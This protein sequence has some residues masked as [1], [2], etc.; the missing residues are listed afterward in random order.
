[1]DGCRGPSLADYIERGFLKD[2]DALGVLRDIASG[3][4]LL[5]E[6]GGA[7]GAISSRTILARDVGGWGFADYG[8]SFRRV[9]FGGSAD[10][11][12]GDQLDP[13]EAQDD[14][15]G[16][17]RTL[18]SCFVPAGLEEDSVCL[19]RLRVAKPQFAPCAEGLLRFGEPP[20]TNAKEFL[21]DLDARFPTIPVPADPSL[22]SGAVVR[23]E[24]LDELRRS[25]VASSGSK[26]A[27]VIRGVAGSG[28]THLLSAL[29]REVPTS[30]LLWAKCR[31]WEL[32]PF[33]AV[34]QLV[35]GLVSE[36]GMP[37]ADLVRQLLAGADEFG[38]FV[39][40]LLPRLDGVEFDAGPVPESKAADDVYTEGVAEVLLRALGKGRHV[41][42]VEDIHWL[43]EASRKVLRRVVD[44]CGAS[45][46]L[47]FTARDTPEHIPQTQRFLTTI[48]ARIAW[49]E[50]LRPLT[51]EQSARLVTA[52]VSALRIAP[53]HSRALAQIADG[54]PLGV[55]EVVRN[56]LDLGLLSPNWTQWRLDTEGLAVLTLPKRVIDLIE[57][58]T[59]RLSPTT[60]RV[61][62][63][64]AVLGDE[65]EPGVLHHAPGHTLEGVRA[66]MMDAQ[67]LSLIERSSGQSRRFIHKCVRDA[68]TSALS[69]RDLQH[70]HS[71]V[72][73]ALRVR[74]GSD[75][76]AQR[77]EVVY[78][79]A[80]HASCAAAICDVDLAFA[81]NLEAGRRAFDAFDNARAVSFLTVANNVA[82]DAQKKQTAI[83]F[84]IAE[85]KLRLGELDGSLADFT[86][87]LERVE[88]GYATA[89]AWSR[90]ATI[91]EARLDSISTV[92][93]L[94]RAFEALGERVP[95][96]A[97]HGALAIL[98][99][100]GSPRKPDPI[101][102]TDSPER[103]RTE[104]LVELLVQYSRSTLITGSIWAMV[105]STTRAQGLAERLGPS[106]LLS[107]ACVMTALLLTLLHRKAAGVQVT[108]RALALA[109]S[110]DDPAAY[111]HCLVSLSA[112][113]G[114]QGDIEGLRT[115][116]TEAVTRYPNWMIPP[117]LG[118]AAC[119]LSVVE[120]FR[121]N[122]HTDWTWGNSASTRA[123]QYEGQALVSELL[124]LRL[125]AAAC[126]RGA[127]EI[128]GEFLGQLQ[129]RTL[130]IAK[131]SAYY[132]WT[133]G[134]RVRTFTES[135]DLGE[136]FEAIVEEVSRAQL[137]P[138]RAHQA[139]AEYYV[140]VAHARV[141][142]CFGEGL[143]ASRPALDAL[144]LAARE[145]ELAV[146]IPLIDAH[147]R[148]VRACVYLFKGNH[149]KAERTFG[150]AEQL[151]REQKAPWVLYAVARGR[152]HMAQRQG[153]GEAARRH[154]RVAER[155][156]SE[157]G[158]VHRLR[159]IREEFNLG[160]DRDSAEQLIMDA[161]RSERHVRA[162]VQ[163]SRL[164]SGNL[165]PDEKARQVLDEM[166]AAFQAER[167]FLLLRDSTE[168]LLTTLGGNG[169]LRVTAARVAGQLDAADGESLDEPTL[170]QVLEA[171]Q[172]TV[173][174]GTA[175]AEPTSLLMVPLTVQ[176]IPV[177]AVALRSASGGA[178]FTAGDGELLTALANQVPIALELAHVLRERERLA[179]DLRQ[180]QKME[181]VGRLAGGIAHDFNNMLSA[182]HVAVDGVMA[183][184]DPQSM[185]MTDL[186]TIQN[187]AERASRLT[188]QLLAFSRRQVFSARPLALNETIN[189]V[190]PML[191]RLI[192]EDIQISTQLSEQ[193]HAV[194][195]DVSQFEQVLMNL[196]VNARDAMPG[197]GRLTVCTSNRRLNDDEKPGL[198]AGDY[199]LLTVSDEGQGMDKATQERIF[200]PFFTTKTADAGTGLGLSMVYGIV[201]QTGGHIEFDSAPG[202]GSEFR[203]FF[204]IT[205][206]AIESIPP[207]SYVRGGRGSGR[208][209]L[210]D[211]EPLVRQA[212]GRSLRRMGYSVS[213]ASNGRQAI[214][215]VTENPR[216]DLIITDVVMPGMNGLEMVEKLASF[217]TKTKVLY[218]S[219]YTDG[220]LDR[221]IGLDDRVDF[222][223]KPMLQQDLLAKVSEM[224][225]GKAPEE[226]ADDNPQR[227]V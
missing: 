210:V 108:G 20:Y 63:L 27:L 158:A 38:R 126:A 58:R 179:E 9:S 194:K 19:E 149:K 89:R 192:G 41:V 21:A 112:L 213:M 195:V 148:V 65:F 68:L 3:L 100:L 15:R 171:K 136:G 218:V 67:Q 140:C 139:V 34:R 181:A 45:C 215:M 26:R 146:K 212:L 83:G 184:V 36:R 134:P 221:G 2:E 176:G 85:A 124:A 33:S 203:I 188:R 11:P 132:Q 107:E 92:N 6:V 25:V 24:E 135:G 197:G 35:E 48:A 90:I 190:V 110:L 94:E 64:A 175:G 137:N 123:I 214:E 109:R 182:I 23:R 96:G 227:L 162:L 157:T 99:L 117:E 54:T 114:W 101:L 72:V 120:V 225:T 75:V 43:D 217:G 105:D 78:Q 30:E 204:P 193:L 42:V 104:L 14:F 185:Q 166:I 142:A 51:P 28:K 22:R 220:V 47:I 133:F 198:T 40:P 160:A 16:L 165:E 102:A 95:G 12:V 219:G 211:D 178:P 55:L 115:L 69:P 196:A 59:Q 46:T 138:R 113:A 61:L 62:R 191:Q 226:T 82:D 76:S 170:K 202:K 216:V 7:H 173:L 155:L 147:A 86:H 80:H 144:R 66:A 224:L 50:T 18:L 91:H 71:H 32:S 74:Y 98:A 153:E 73:E 13:P 152:A 141:H 79:M 103:P 163:I 57:Q 29:G 187:A 8:A 154:A 180:S 97:F 88:A 5:H 169:T 183:E 167:G 49:D 174:A 17:G 121:G 150:V 201:R 31:N 116:A 106:Q 130:A 172:P 145:L 200:E 53:E 111:A 128:H 205:T 119:S 206:E 60:V 129:A 81:S 77:S 177:G 164:S 84:L 4:A 1:M 127:E 159:W 161:E 125:R 93:C 189:E 87:E 223:Q 209:L 207:T 52:Y 56:A 122:A 208:I 143:D 131:E 156:A 10:G 39:L 186:E 118:L 222:M 44:R 199:A 151:G 37:R 70:L 168:G